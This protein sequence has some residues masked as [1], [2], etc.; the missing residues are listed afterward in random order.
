M[1]LLKLSHVKEI[2]VLSLLTVSSLLSGCGTN[3]LPSYAAEPLKLSRETN[4]Q[5]VAKSKEKPQPEVER[6][7][8]EPLPGVV[9]SFI[10][11]SIW[12]FERRVNY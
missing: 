4:S 1:A 12:G 8:Q 9:G 10:S 6:A 5:N 3:S 11:P 7:K 2:I